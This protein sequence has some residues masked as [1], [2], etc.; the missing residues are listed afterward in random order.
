VAI[1]RAPTG[2]T[3]VEQAQ[4]EIFAEEKILPGASSG[5]R[6]IEALDPHQPLDL[7]PEADSALYA[8][9]R[10]RLRLAFAFSA[11]SCGRP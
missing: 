5:F 9:T 6:L 3:G 8:A 2:Q 1:D 10:A 11:F 4:L 7:L